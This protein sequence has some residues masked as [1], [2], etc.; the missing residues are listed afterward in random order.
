MLV[1][2]NILGSTAESI[3]FFLNS[4][5]ITWK[6]L[7]V[8]V[9]GAFEKFLSNRGNL[10]KNKVQS[11]RKHCAVAAIFKSQHLAQVLLKRNEDLVDAHISEIYE[12]RPLHIS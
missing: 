7:D 11:F 6:V 10:H 1:R 3:V 8:G 2:H 4:D 5:D 12:K 9:Y